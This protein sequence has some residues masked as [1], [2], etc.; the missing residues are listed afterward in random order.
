MG[1]IDEFVEI[2]NE[3]NRVAKNLFKK[4]CALGYG[5]DFLEKC[6]DVN[7]IEQIILKL[8]PNSTRSITTICSLLSAYANYTGND[9]AYQM[10]KNIDRNL[11]WEKAK[12][13]AKKKYISHETYLNV[14]HEISKNEKPKELNGFYYRTLFKVIYEG[15]YCDDMSVIANLK[16]SDI[17]G[18]I[19]ELHTDDKESYKIKLPSDLIKDLKKLSHCDEWERKNRFGEFRVKTFGKYPDSCFKIENRKSSSET[20]YRFGYYNRLRKIAKEYIGYN[21]VPLQLFISGIMYRICL[22]LDE[23]NISLDDAF[24]DQNRDKK[25]SNIITAELL[26]CNHKIPV[27]AFREQVIGHLDVFR[28]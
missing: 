24:A 8:S 28:E 12:P 16:S 1:K 13:N 18:N 23:N 26:R 9:I 3:T 2:Q 6:Q 11:L 25:V 22:K 10:I 17:K 21:L 20:T 27:R 19:V 7:S 4:L 15:V 14:I 5:D